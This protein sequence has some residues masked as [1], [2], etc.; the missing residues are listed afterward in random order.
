MFKALQD[1]INY[2]LKIREH[3]NLNALKYVSVCACV[4][5]KLTTFHSEA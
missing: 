1:Y 5:L 3:V 4:Y 2:I